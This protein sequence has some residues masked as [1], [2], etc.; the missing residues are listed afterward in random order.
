MEVSKFEKYKKAARGFR[1]KN[2]KLIGL[3]CRKPTAAGI[4]GVSSCTSLTD[5]T[6]YLQPHR[7]R[8]QLNSGWAISNR[9]LFL[10]S[11]PFLHTLLF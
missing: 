5:H 11:F 3:S 4:Q 10:S 6:V 2:M 9:F 7:H 1:K 8:K